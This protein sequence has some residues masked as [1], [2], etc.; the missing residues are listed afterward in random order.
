[1]DN[2]Y[3]LRPFKLNVINIG[4]DPTIYIFLG[5]VPSAILVAAN[6][7]KRNN[8]TLNWDNESEKILKNLY[9]LKN[10]LLKELKEKFEPM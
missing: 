5:A 6:S 4:R 8:N 7:F 9:E 2:P 1:M 10:K 3:K